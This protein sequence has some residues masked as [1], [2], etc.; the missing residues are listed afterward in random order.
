[1]ISPTTSS[2][3]VLRAIA[4]G[5]PVAPAPTLKPE[6]EKK[7]KQTSTQL[8]A[9]FTAYM[10]EEFN[11]GLPGSEGGFASQVYADMFK[12]SIATKVAQSGSGRGLADQIYQSAE[13]KALKHGD[14]R[15]VSPA[16]A[17]TNAAAAAAIGGSSI[18]LRTLAATTPSSSL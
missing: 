18:T 13:K 1:M 9:S 12:Q 10:M 16:E 3:P 7:L 17:A 5:P 14:G 6:D 2:E 8:E 11:K 4:V 15:V